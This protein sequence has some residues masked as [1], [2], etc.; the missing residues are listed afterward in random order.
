MGQKKPTLGNLVWKM[1]G[2]VCLMSNYNEEVEGRDLTADLLL[3]KHSSSFYI[4]AWSDKVNF[5]NYTK[6]N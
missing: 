3:V 2:F 5:S 1:A 4:C 6:S